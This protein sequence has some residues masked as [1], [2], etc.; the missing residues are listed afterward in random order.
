MVTAEMLEAELGGT[1]M[2]RSESGTESK[3]HGGSEIAQSLAANSTV[4]FQMV[5]PQ[6]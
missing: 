3:Y 1:V 5:Q 6:E 4:G 2:A